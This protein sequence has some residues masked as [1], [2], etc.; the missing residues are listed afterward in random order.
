MK[1]PNKIGDGLLANITDT[2]LVS[3]KYHVNTCYARYM[4]SNTYSEKQQQKRPPSEAASASDAELT[5]SQC[6][7]QRKNVTKSAANDHRNK[8]CIV[9]G[10]IKHEGSTSRNRISEPGRAK[11]FL[12]TIRFNKDDVYTQCALLNSPGDVF[13]ADIMCHAGCIKNYI[14][15]FQRDVGQPMHYD[16]ETVNADWTNLFLEM[17][18]TLE[19][20]KKG[21]AISDSRDASNTKVE[22]AVCYVRLLHTHSLSHHHM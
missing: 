2:E 6:K 20:H 19:L 22:D 1:L 11:Q 17:V 7:K 4:L 3:L 18:S 15:R 10:Q 16:E 8:P 12:R 21:Y 13:A 5:T 14:Q 9:C